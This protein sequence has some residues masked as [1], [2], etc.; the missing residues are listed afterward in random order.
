MRSSPF[1]LRAAPGQVRLTLLA[2]L[3]WRGSAEI[4]D[5]LVELLI[6]LVHKINA[7]AD[8]RVE[9]AT[10]DLRRVRGKEGVLFRLAEA[11]VEHPDELAAALHRRRDS[12]AGSPAAN[13]NT[14]PTPCAS[15]LTAP[16]R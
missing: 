12:C 14:P 13:R 9:R 6:G 3:C 11:T 8:R 5:A 16:L 15:P 4:T 7:R 1:D 2:A 10:E